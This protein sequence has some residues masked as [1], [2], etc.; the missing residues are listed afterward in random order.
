MQWHIAVQRNINSA[1]FAE[2][3]GD[4]G[5]DCIGD[6]VPGSDIAAMLDAINSDGVICRRR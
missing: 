2:K 6:P 3:G 5:G 4:C 1:L